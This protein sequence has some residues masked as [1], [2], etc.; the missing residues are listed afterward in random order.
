MKRSVNMDDVYAWI[1]V[2]S[3]PQ[4]FNTENMYW[5]FSGALDIL[6]Y[7]GLITQV[8]RYWWLDHYIIKHIVET[9][10]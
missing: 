8:E 10:V 7:L 1:N 9:G 3:N 4:E 6:H 5:R 2:M